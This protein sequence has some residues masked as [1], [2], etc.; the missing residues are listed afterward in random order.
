MITLIFLVHNTLVTYLGP[1]DM[2]PKFLSAIS[3]TNLIACRSMLQS[4]EI[5]HK[6]IIS[7]FFKSL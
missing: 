1:P 2:G 4:F 5:L 3:P 7:N 6:K